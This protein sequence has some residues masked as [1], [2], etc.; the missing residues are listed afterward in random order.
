M[1]LG[2][3]RRKFDRLNR[4]Y[5]D[6]ALPVPQLAILPAGVK[7][8]AMVSCT[9][10]GGYWKIREGE[11]LIEIRAMTPDVH[12]TFLHAVLLHEM[13]HL[14]IGPQHAHRSRKWNAAVRRLGERGAMIEVL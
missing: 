9:D 8:Q 12:P 11:H 5:W 14:E 3:L 13:I 4:Q 2:N 6:G 10:W 7:G 1:T